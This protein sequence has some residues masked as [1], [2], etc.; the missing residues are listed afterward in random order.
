MSLFDKK[1]RDLEEVKALRAKMD[2]LDQEARDNWNNPQWRAEM[3]A[4]LTEEIYRGFTHE[5]LLGIIAEVE[6]ANFDARIFVKEVRGLRAHWIARGGYIEASTLKANVM[7]LPRD[8]I[9]FHVMEFEDKLLTNFSETQAT[10]VDLAIQRMDA[11]VNS[12]VFR[13]FQLA[14]PSGGDNYLSHSGLDLDQLNAAMREVRDASLSFDI[15]IIGRSTMTDQIQDALLSSNSVGFLPSTSEDIQR[16]G[17][18]GTYRGANIV[19]LKN[20]LDDTNT[21]FFP[22]NELFVVARDASKFAFWGGLKEKEWIE[23]D[24]WYW[25]YAARRD[26][27]GT[28]HRPERLRRIVD[29]SI[30]P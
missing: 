1:V 27:G 8:T 9:G 5:N 2:I 6:N 15:S 3:A 4:D 14:A 28:V 22:A 13:M 7:E 25:H 19:T 11:E 20:Y 18:L 16:R 17:V 10:L 30:A 29:T 21:S 26:F 23:N 12:L 24:N